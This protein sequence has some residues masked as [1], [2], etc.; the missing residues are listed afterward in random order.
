MRNGAVRR[1]RSGEVSKLRMGDA[2]RVQSGTASGGWIRVPF[3]WRSNPAFRVLVIQDDSG[4]RDSDAGADFSWWI[5]S[6]YEATRTWGFGRD[7]AAR[8]PDVQA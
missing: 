6:Q 4:T 7:P 8:I 3:L 2:I 5:Q 1:G